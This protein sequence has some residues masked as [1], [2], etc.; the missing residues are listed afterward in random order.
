MSF[1]FGGGK[2]SF[3]RHSAGVYLMRIL[4]RSWNISRLMFH[5]IPLYSGGLGSECKERDVRECCVH[6]CFI[7]HDV[8][9]G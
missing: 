2:S 3:W 4:I 9:L 6:L 1:G 5:N 8:N 7:A